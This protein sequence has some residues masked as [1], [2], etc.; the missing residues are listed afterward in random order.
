[1]GNLINVE[2]LHQ[3]YLVQQQQH[4]AAT[5]YL[6][7]Q[8]Q[9]ETELLIQQLDEKKLLNHQLEEAKATK[10][11]TQLLEREK[12]LK[13]QLQ[14]LEEA[15]LFQLQ[16]KQVE[17]TKALKRQAEINKLIK[18]KLQ[19]LHH[20]QLQKQEKDQQQLVAM[21]IDLRMRSNANFDSRTPLQYKCSIRPTALI[22]SCANKPAIPLLNFVKEQ[23]RFI[24]SADNQIS[25]KYITPFQGEPNHRVFGH[26]KCNKCNKKWSSGSSWTNKWQ[27]CK[28]CESMIY[29][30]E[31]HSLEIKARLEDVK[32]LIPH[33]T[34][35]C[36]K[37]VELGRI[38]CPSLYRDVEI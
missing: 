24:V 20:Q 4:L 16:L 6:K 34:K 17:H 12:Q 18:S 30:F 33:D 19:I 9:L 8:Q 14:Q 28:K 21:L 22:K 29:P 27:K 23:E 36:Q 10:I 13:N 31:Q 11:Q 5:Q 35:R 25:L 32:S 2:L 3:Q 15:K 1:M 38:C 37:C 26:F 7:K